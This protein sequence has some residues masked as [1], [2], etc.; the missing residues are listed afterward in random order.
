MAVATEHTPGRWDVRRWPNGRVAIGHRMNG[1]FV[2]IAIVLQTDRRGARTANAFVLAASKN[3]LEALKGMVR[4][5]RVPD[6]EA[7]AH[8]EFADAVAQARAAIAEAEGEDR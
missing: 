6:E 2:A 7:W 3:M 1:R 8:S 5:F 4:V